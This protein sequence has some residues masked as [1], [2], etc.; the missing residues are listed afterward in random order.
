M[1]G[2]WS[3]QTSTIQYGGLEDKE[4]YLRFGFLEKNSTNL[5]PEALLSLEGAVDFSS[6]QLIHEDGD[7]GC[8]LSLREESLIAKVNSTVLKSQEYESP[9]EL[10]TD[11]FKI[12][13][14]QIPQ[15]NRVGFLIST[16]I[17]LNAPIQLRVEG[18]VI[19]EAD[20][21]IVSG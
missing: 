20:F 9:V 14:S 5:D 2:L 21:V 3:R 11:N 13:S 6:I 7:L 8:S 19:A 15:L 16:G 12:N 4:C 10:T 1:D 18:E 17:D